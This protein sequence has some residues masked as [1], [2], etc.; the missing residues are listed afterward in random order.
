M[1][2]AETSRAIAYLAP[3]ARAFWKLDER[4]EAFTWHN[5]KTILFCQELA[6]ILRALGERPLPPLSAILLLTAATR[7][8]WSELK[9]EALEQLHL[10]LGRATLRHHLSAGTTTR[11]AEQWKAL[12]AG[13]D[14]VHQLPDELRSSPK[15]KAELLASMAEGAGRN[16]S[17]ATAVSVLALLERGGHLHEPPVD[18][19]ADDSSAAFLQLLRGYNWL[20]VGLLKIDAEKL[21]LRCSTGLDALPLAAPVEL[22]A[23]QIRSLL[24]DLSNGNELVGMAR[25]ARQLMAA[26][27][28][29]RPISQQEDLPLGGVSDVSNRGPLDKLL[30]SEL[31]HDDLTLS[32]RVAMNEALYLQREAPPKHPPRLRRVL[33]DSGLRMW[34][35]PRVFATSV[36]LALAATTEGDLAAEVLRADDRDCRPVDLATRSGL[37]AQLGE[38]GTTIHPGDALEGLAT[39]TAGEGTVVD[40]ILITSHDTLADPVFDRALAR[41]ELAN[42]HIATVDRS[43]AFR[44][45]QVTRHARQPVREAQFSLDEIV[46]DGV[47]DSL[48]DARAMHGEPAL[49][50]QKRLPLRLSMSSNRNGRWQMRSA[51]ALAIT[52]DRR[53]LQ[54]DRAGVGGLQLTD[55]LPPGIL[56]WATART[57]EQHRALAV[58]GTRGSS[59][60]HLLTID[61]REQTCLARRLPTTGS[62]P[63]SVTEYQGTIFVFFDAVVEAFNLNCDFVGRLTMTPDMHPLQGRFIRVDEWGGGVFKALAYDGTKLVLEPVP[64]LGMREQPVVTLFDAE[65]Q[66]GPVALFSGCLYFTATE[67]LCSI[68]KVP[69]LPLT[70]HN[71]SRDGSYVVVR[72]HTRHSTPTNPGRYHCISVDETRCVHSSSAPLHADNFAIGKLIQPRDMRHRFHRIAATSDGSLALATARGTWSKFVVEGLTLRLRPCDAPPSS[73]QL[74]FE[75]YELPRRVGY[76]LRKAAWSDGSTAWIDSRGLL[77]FRS[78]DGRLPEASIALSSGELAGWLSDN[79]MWGSE[80]YLT[81]SPD[82]Y[83]DVFV[84]A[85]L[86]PFLGRL[87]C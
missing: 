20:H 49:L 34:G 77:H 65:N 25:L 24:A 41:L 36:A 28:L 32:V 46:T 85:F 7:D 6:G 1:P 81:R 5:G 48:I 80:Y 74:S 4:G 33:L 73:G 50:R 76:R 69:L 10:A 79:T 35:V 42:L 47:T 78:S 54:W 2:P 43:G 14:K 61:T 86:L 21:A 39:A 67:S 40:T 26:V 30:L 52:H 60:L 27:F 87:P 82:Y 12:F 37:I 75:D 3:H 31:A 56:H 51:G 70:F 44:L 13:L 22:P 64:L 57:D 19:S 63:R 16:H 17:S 66:R 83:A 62:V 38:L 9:A 71:I 29:P 58:I 68:D 11:F 72:E 59:G 84:R 23:R 45:L 8:N 53:L 15:A 18:D 55:E